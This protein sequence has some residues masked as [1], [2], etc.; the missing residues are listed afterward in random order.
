[1]HFDFANESGDL[2]YNS[3][4]VFDPNLFTVHVIVKPL[5]LQNIRN[6]DKIRSFDALHFLSSSEHLDP[7][8]LLG[9]NIYQMFFNV[10]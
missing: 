10:L 8:L 4:P 1:L 2:T 5:L 3:E 6:L 7:L 9:S